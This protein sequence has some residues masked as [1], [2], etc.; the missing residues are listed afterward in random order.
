VVE[1]A[2]NVRVA[3][4][5]ADRGMSEADARA[6]IAAQATDEQRRSVADVVIVNDGTLDELD[7]EVDA[8]WR[9]LIRPA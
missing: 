3:R 1:A 5:V 7:A 2:P 9:E 4:L 6:R 8:V